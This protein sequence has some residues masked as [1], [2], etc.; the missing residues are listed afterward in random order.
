M[1]FTDVILALYLEG[2]PSHSHDDDEEV[3]DAAPLSDAVV[4]AFAL[5]CAIG[6]EYPDRVRAI[7]EQTHPGAVDEIIEECKAPL[8][9]QITEA[10]NATEA[11]EPEDF[12]EPLVEALGQGDHADADSAQNAL[13]MS[14]EYG[15]IVAHMERGTAMVVRNAFNR[16]QETSVESYEAGDSA[17]MPAGPDPYQSLQDLAKEIVT[18]YEA[19]VGF[20]P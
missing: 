8:S 7:L 5:G 3:F 2:L 14:F 6:L 19:D 17:E 18:A 1:A 4:G 9:A 11:L 20:W 15:L 16:D 12:V 13:S 10:R